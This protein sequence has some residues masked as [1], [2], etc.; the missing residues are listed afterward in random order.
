MS[1]STIA[2]ICFLLTIGCY[3]LSKHLHRRFKKVWLIP[4]VSVPLVLVAIVVSLNISYTDYIN[5][6]HWLIWMLGPALSPLQ[7]QCTR[8]ETSSN[9]T[10]CLS[11][12]G[13]W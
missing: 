8:T 13:L 5:E 3:Y 6:S 4:L 9:A 12:L 11:Q 2:F 10:G 1:H 7:F